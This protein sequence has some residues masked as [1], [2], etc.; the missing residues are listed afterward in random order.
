MW[1]KT[2]ATGAVAFNA[3]IGLC[4]KPSDSSAG[5]QDPTLVMNILHS[6][7]MMT[8]S[9]SGTTALIAN[10][11]TVR[12]IA[13]ALEHLVSQSWVRDPENEGIPMSVLTL[14]GRFASTP[15]CVAAFKPVFAP[16]LMKQWTPIMRAVCV[17]KAPAQLAEI[18]AINRS[19]PPAGVSAA[20]T[21]N[22]EGKTVGICSVCATAAVNL[23]GRCKAVYYCT[24]DHQVTTSHHPTHQSHHYCCRSHSDCGVWCFWVCRNWIGRRVI[25]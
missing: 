20:E 16:N 17:M 3:W 4:G 19:F 13:Q 14:C 12:V 18:N 7:S 2:S 6:L 25:N 23:C 11:S 9:K 8:Q 1:L 21:V 22:S 24:A 5:E 15:E 10:A